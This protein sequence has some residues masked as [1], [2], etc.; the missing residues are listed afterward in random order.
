MAGNP[1]PTLKDYLFAWGAD[2]DHPCG[3]TVELSVGHHGFVH[4]P[5]WRKP[6]SDEPWPFTPENCGYGGYTAGEW[7]RDGKL[8]FCIGCGLDET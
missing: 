7:T 3:C 6:I 4:V 2:P 8:L 5:S 1:D